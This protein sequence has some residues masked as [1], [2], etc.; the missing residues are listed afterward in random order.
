[1]RKDL[2][3]RKQG[4][5]LSSDPLQ[6]LKN[7]SE[8]EA[9]LHEKINASLAIDE[10][11]KDAENARN[12]WMLRFQVATGLMNDNPDNSN[13]QTLVEQAK[14][15]LD[16]TVKKLSALQEQQAQSMKT[17]Q[18]AYESL[19]QLQRIELLQA[20]GSAMQGH[21]NELTE[22]MTRTAQ[23][24]LS[25]PEVNREALRSEYYMQAMLELSMEKG[26]GNHGK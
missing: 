7:R 12:E 10:A 1:M 24:E 21:R 25:S 15:H 5:S 18:A 2:A 23:L 20:S 26:S 4:G 19:K 13:L 3:R 16:L 17:R 8:I 22:I 11:M 6:I 9:G 14:I